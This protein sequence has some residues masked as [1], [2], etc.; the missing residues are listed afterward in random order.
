MSFKYPLLLGVTAGARG[1][2]PNFWAILLGVINVN[3]PY[4]FGKDYPAVM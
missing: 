4:N 1:R 3:R 2:L